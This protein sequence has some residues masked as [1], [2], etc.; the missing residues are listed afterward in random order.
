MRKENGHLESICVTISEKESVT[1]LTGTVSFSSCMG[2]FD[3]GGEMDRI[4]KS[5]KIRHGRLE[6]R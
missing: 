2:D 3:V 4:I 6:S 5:Y 1:N